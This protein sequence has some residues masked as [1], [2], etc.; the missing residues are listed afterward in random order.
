VALLVKHAR[1]YWL[2]LAENGV[3]PFVIYDL[4]HTCL[5]RWAKRMDTFTL[6]KLAGHGD[7]S[8]TMRYVHLKDD[9]V[10]AAME[11]AEAAK[12]GHK[13]RHG[14]ENEGRGPLAVRP[15]LN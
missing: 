15:V 13:T 1:Y 9:D 5:T 2:P 7:F 6:M 14:N 4:R 12:R 11:K 3:S 10:R 8:T